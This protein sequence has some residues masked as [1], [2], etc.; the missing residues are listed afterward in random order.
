[1]DG[2]LPRSE[3][4]SG[5]KRKAKGRLLECKHSRRLPREG[6]SA[7]M[8]IW[9]MTSR[10][11]L[12]IYI[13]AVVVCTTLLVL[14]LNSA[15]L[16]GVYQAFTNPSAFQH[17]WHTPPPPYPYD[18]RKQH[19]TGSGVVVLKTG[20]DGR[21]V[22]AHMD[23]RIGIEAL[24]ANTVRYATECWTGPPN[25]SHRVPITYQLR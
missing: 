1:M 5:N 8:G 6:I 17:G 20:G 10:K 22:E 16:Y 13:A 7:G 21:I 14:F 19:L 2:Q 23:P 9:K 24:D 15:M 3:T 11:L 4:Q 18:A 12:I 25:S